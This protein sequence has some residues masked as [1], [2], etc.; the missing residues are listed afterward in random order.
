M[1]L[2]GAISRGHLPVSIVYL[3]DGRA[4]RRGWSRHDLAFFREAEILL[5]EIVA[6]DGGVTD[7]GDP[8]FVFCDTDSGEV[9]AHFAKINGQYI[10]CMNG[11][12]ARRVLLDA[13][14][15]FRDRDPD[16]RSVSVISR[17]VLEAPFG[18]LS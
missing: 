17:R 14:T 8:W 1:I 9:L 3:A 18:E 2:V 5:R 10:V 15:R 7:E 6:T 16:R 11:G 4:N 13:A 12:F